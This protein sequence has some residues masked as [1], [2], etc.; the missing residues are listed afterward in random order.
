MIQIY[1]STPATGY[2]A[3]RRV[4]GARR[5]QKVVMRLLNQALCFYCLKYKNLTFGFIFHKVRGVH[6]SFKNIVLEE[7][8]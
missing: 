6:H 5:E 8:A 2:S 1:L 4:E 7:F 3:W